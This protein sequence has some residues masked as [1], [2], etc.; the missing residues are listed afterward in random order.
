MDPCRHWAEAKVDVK[1]FA[2]QIAAMNTVAG[3]PAV[4][5]DVAMDFGR[6]TR[7]VRADGSYGPYQYNTVESTKIPSSFKIKS[8]QLTL[9]HV[10]GPF[11]STDGFTPDKTFK[12]FAESVST[13]VDRDVVLVLDRSG[14]MIYFEDEDLLADTL[15]DLS[16][17]THPVETEG[18]V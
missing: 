10:F 7:T 2:A 4:I 12:V 13:Q 18:T 3:S 14:S 9:P 5:P 6:S 16:Q 1:A 17:E 15:Y 11:N 8:D